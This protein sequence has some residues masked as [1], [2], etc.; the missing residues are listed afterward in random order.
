MSLR[1]WPPLVEDF[2]TGAFANGTAAL[3]SM[4][5]TSNLTTGMYLVSAGVLGFATGGALRTRID[6]A[7]QVAFIDG[8]AGAPAL[9]FISDTNTGIY[10]VSADT[11][12]LVTGGV[13]RWGVSTAG[14]LFPQLD[15]IYDL[16]GTVNKISRI[17]VRDITATNSIDISGGTLTASVI[18]SSGATANIDLRSISSGNTN[19]K[20]NKTNAT[21]TVTWALAQLGSSTQPSGYLQVQDNV[22]TMYIPFWA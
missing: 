5:F 2:I 9:S 20:F 21:P 4:T 15:A 18:N 1:L 6:S 3:P 16:G 17:Y 10:N 11:L 19:I 12:G 8:T 13:L 7:G 22:T 14:I